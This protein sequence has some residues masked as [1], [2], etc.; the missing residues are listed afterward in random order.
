MSSFEIV[1]LSF[2]LALDAFAVSLC[3]ASSGALK[4]RRSAVRLA[5]HFGLF[6]ALMPVLGWFL[7]HELEKLIERYDHW[8]AFLLLFLVGAKMIIESLKPEEEKDNSN[9][10]K[11]MR[12]VMLSVATSIDALVVG[13]S[14]GLVR[15]NIWYPSVMIGLITGAMS[16]LG[17]FLGKKLGD[18]FGKRMEI[19]GGVIIIAIGLKILIEHLSS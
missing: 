11:G 8:I 12:L 9:P 15:V 4:G 3:A 16:L 10:S 2:G 5:F 1:I 13:F 17:I 7:G 14:L 19:L 18:R 6:Q